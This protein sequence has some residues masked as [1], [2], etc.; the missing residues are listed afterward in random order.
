MQWHL[1]H[2][3]VLCNPSPLSSSKTFPSL[4]NKTPYSLQ[5]FLPFALF[6]QPW[7]T[8]ILPSF[9][10]DVPILDIS[11]NLNPTVRDF[12]CLAS[13][14]GHVFKVHS[15]CCMYQFFLWLNNNPIVWVEHVVLIYSSVW[16]TWETAKPRGKRMGMLVW[17]L[18][19]ADLEIKDLCS[20]L[21]GRWCW[22]TLWRE[23]EMR[24]GRE[25]GQSQFFY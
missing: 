17:V 24:Q 3:T 25:G 1:V 10:V 2:F 9:S 22:K 11:C 18:P 4:Q 5:Q 20:G 23:R 21:F 12:L 6:P 8:T 19:E 16:A 15:L 7:A 14:T 13:F